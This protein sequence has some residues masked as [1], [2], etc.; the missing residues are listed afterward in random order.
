LSFCQLATH[1]FIYKVTWFVACF[2]LDQKRVENKKDGCCPCFVSHPDFELPDSHDSDLG[3]IV[4]KKLASILEVSFIK[5][6]VP[7]GKY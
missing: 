3:Y 2:T 6:K 5:V 7:K 4:M 1:S